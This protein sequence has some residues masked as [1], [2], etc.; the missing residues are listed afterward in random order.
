MLVFGNKILG[1][2]KKKSF[3]QN[4]TKAEVAPLEAEQCPHAAVDYIVTKPMSQKPTFTLIQT[5][6]QTCY[7]TMGG[8]LRYDSTVT[9]KVVGWDAPTGF[10]VPRGGFELHFY[11]GKVQ[12]IESAIL[13]A[14]FAGEVSFDSTVEIDCELLP[15]ASLTDPQKS[16]FGIYDSMEVASAEPD[17]EA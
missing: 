10:D 14:A 3:K 8:T 7:D 16:L 4:G 5:D 11:T 2:V 6:Y 13:L 9:D 12:Y 1:Y 15:I 17:P